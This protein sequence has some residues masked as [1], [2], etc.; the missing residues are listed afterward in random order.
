MK[1]KRFWDLIIIIIAG[2]MLFSAYKLFTIYRNDKQTREQYEQLEQLIQKD[3]EETV[4]DT[5]ITSQQKYQSVYDQNNDF[6]GWIYIPG[7]E[8][9]Y[10][11]MHTPSNPEYYLRREAVK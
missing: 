4:E 10:P 9:S 5:H 8:L 7:T 6:A 11:V 2:V 3:T 1:K